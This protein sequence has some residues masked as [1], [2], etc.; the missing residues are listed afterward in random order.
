MEK[1][2]DNKKVLL[3]WTNFNLEPQG[4]QTNNKKEKKKERTIERK[5]DRNANLRMNRKVDLNRLSIL[6]SDWCAVSISNMISKCINKTLKY[7][8]KVPQNQQIKKTTIT[9]FKNRA[10]KPICGWWPW[11]MEC[12]SVIRCHVCWW[13]CN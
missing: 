2:F 8:F 3:T 4:Q 1:C 11:E 6:E 12:W 13:K 10:L 9:V 7:K 5:K